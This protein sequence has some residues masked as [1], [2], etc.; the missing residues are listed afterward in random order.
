MQSQTI[1]KQFFSGLEL[2]I[3]D[4]NDESTE[5]L[6]LF[7]EYLGFKV[8]CTS[9]ANQAMELLDNST[10]DIIISELALPE[11]DGYSF[12]KKIKN[13]QMFNIREIPVIALSAWLS[14]YDD[15]ALWAGFD[16]F[17]PKPIVWEEIT[18]KMEALVS[19]KKSQ[20][21]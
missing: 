17:I 11:E 3:L 19:R 14:K 6:S 21:N 16:M 8:L 2:L 13:H 7:F 4:N 12:I 5:I 10:V 18:E 20:L 15:K 9:T 1:Q